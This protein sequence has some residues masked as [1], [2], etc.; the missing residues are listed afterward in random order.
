MTREKGKQT[1]RFNCSPG[2]KFFFNGETSQGL[3][4]S[5]GEKF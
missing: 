3:E 5:G 2:I 1:R 4:A